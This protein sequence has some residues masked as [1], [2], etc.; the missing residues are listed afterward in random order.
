LIELT[1]RVTAADLAYIA[2]NLP[3]K[4]LKEFGG[5]LPKEKAAEYKAAAQKT[6][7]AYFDDKPAVFMGV[8]ADG[9]VFVAATEAA[10]RRKREF[11]LLT[12]EM[13]ARTLDGRPYVW[14]VI[15][16]WYEETVRWCRWLGARFHDRVEDPVMG[17]CVVI[18]FCLADVVLGRGRKNG[19]RA[20]DNR[21]A[22]SDL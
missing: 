9:F 17:R 14:A 10:K 13:L 20:G 22:V 6:Y 18:T 19:S 1:D 2:E 8:A 3:E 11:L 16:L 5:D 21:D 7:I 12:R 15:P 4:T